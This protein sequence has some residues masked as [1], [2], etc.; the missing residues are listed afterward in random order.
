MICIYIPM[1][2]GT[3]AKFPSAVRFDRTSA[4]NFPYTTSCQLNNNKL[5]NADSWER[6]LTAKHSLEAE[7]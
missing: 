4:M 1:I 6:E 7:T 2:I 3:V 5:R